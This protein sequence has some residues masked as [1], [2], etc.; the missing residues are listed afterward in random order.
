MSEG[1]TSGYIAET[2]NS[3]G[4]YIGQW[5][6][7]TPTYHDAL[8]I[9]AEKTRRFWWGQQIDLSTTAFSLMLATEGRR[10][11]IP[12][13][14]AF[15]ALA[16][17][18]SLSFAQNLFFLALLL[19]PSPLPGGD[20]NLEL[21]VAPVPAPT[22]TRLRDNLFPP[23]PNGWVPDVRF[24]YAT[25]A[26][27]LSLTLILPYAAGTSSF[28]TTALLARASSFLLLALPRIIPERWGSVLKHP[29]DVHEP[30]TKLFRFL[31][32]SAFALHAKT[33]LIALISNAPDSHYH[34]HSALLPWD[35]EER[36]RW[37]QGTS[38]VGKVLGSTSDHPVVAA[39]GW[40]VLL[41][42]LSLGLWA[43]VRGINSRNLISCS[44][45]F[46][47]QQA[48]HSGQMSVTDKRH[49]TPERTLAELNHEHED[50]QHMTT[51]R[52]GRA[53]RGRVGSIASS[54]G[55]S[56]DIPTSPTAPT[57]SKR[58]RGRP[59]KTKRTAQEDTDEESISTQATTRSSRRTNKGRHHHQDY[60][61][62]DA[63]IPTPA[64]ARSA[65]EGDEL[66]P[67]DEINGE[68]AALVWGLAAFGGLPS[69]CAA[70]FGGECISR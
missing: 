24:F 12:L 59:K 42:A 64:T 61:S 29:H 31:S 30:L 20:E 69:A 32:M 55:A 9:V 5:L 46:T 35:I 13:L 68:S 17:L 3:T 11:K 49:H 19:A 52:R 22:W 16:H 50:N 60:D 14:T 10:R 56:E 38:A 70:V 4:L 47:S 8:E 21:P 34:R 40:D 48:S 28:A 7:D 62:D 25:I 6:S 36:S 53:A 41:C 66:P 39:V 37:E 27:N 67:N 1:G 26:L 33:S 63:Y 15:L 58:G 45:P 23:K 57:P 54:T 18:V 2:K 43:A 65:L 44:I 51:R